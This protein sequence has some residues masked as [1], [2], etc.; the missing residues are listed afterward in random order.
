MPRRQEYS[1]E[2]SLTY[3]KQA[4]ALRKNDFICIQEHPCKILKIESSKNG[5]H[6]HAK[7]HI[8]AV[9]IFTGNKYEDSAPTGHNVTVP[10]VE[11][12][13]YQVVGISE[14]YLDLIDTNGEEADQIQIPDEFKELSEKVKNSMEEGTYIVMV[15]VQSAMGIEKIISYKEEK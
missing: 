11:K 12:N 8:L 3:P 9:D 5:K 15:C 14:D 10:V 13:D 4:G 6:G 2:T 1:D 7:A